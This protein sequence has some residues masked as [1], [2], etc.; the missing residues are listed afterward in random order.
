MKSIE[1]FHITSYDE[2]NRLIKI[3]IGVESNCDIEFP[4]S[5][6]FSLYP[7]NWLLK[8]MQTIN[9]PFDAVLEN[10]HID[11]VFRDSYYIYFSNQHFNS[12]RFCK[13]LSFFKMGDNHICEEMFFSEDGR[14]KIKDTFIGSC[15]IKPTIKGSI[16][17]TLLDPSIFIPNNHTDYLYERLTDFTININ[18]LPLKIRSFPYS[19]QDTETTSCAEITLI[20]IIEYFANRYA[21]YKFIYPSDIVKIVKKDS[22]E[23]V[24]PTRGM[25]YTQ[26]AKVFTEAGFS[27]RLYFAQT[28]QF[29]G[30]SLKKIWHYYIESGI[31]VAMALNDTE[32]VGHSIIGIGHSSKKKD[33]SEATLTH[34]NGFSFIDT[35]DLYED[36]VIMDDNN[37]PFS[38]RSYEQLTLKDLK[39]MA[40]AVPLAKRMFMEAKDAFDIALNI[41]TSDVFKF[42]E[43]SQP[44]E[45]YK[46][47]GD[48]NNPFILRL[49]LTSAKSYKLYRISCKEDDILLKRIYANVPLPRFIWICEIYT[50][51]GYREN[52]TI[53]EIV[54]DATSSGKSNFNSLVSL[55][56]LDRFAVRTPEETF[57]EMSEFF[58]KKKLSDFKTLTGFKG[59]LIQVPFC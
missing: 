57:Y 2:V 51:Q 9:F 26:L 58:L 18:G 14:K 52:R 5:Q 55:R 19:M 13:R 24:L 16:G 15:V 47:L 4:K 43:L 30:F 54:L 46:C 17:K 50:K 53:G 34:R 20:N 41:I 42:R 36:Y 11:R 6:S 22:F 35:A 12:S 40:L 7:Q 49:F 39:P 38:I 28:L 23:R 45:K 56:Y 59:N 3:I 27:P 21:D 33:Y 1:Y 44:F 25:K 32:T 37:I 29:E 31:P 8:V 48:V 10:Y